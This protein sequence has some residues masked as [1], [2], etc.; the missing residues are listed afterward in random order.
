MDL[1]LHLLQLLCMLHLH[2][3]DDLLEADEPLE[4]LLVPLREHR[5]LPILK[6]F[7]LSHIVH[8]SFVCKLFL[9]LQDLSFALFQV[10]L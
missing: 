2:I 4:R 8:L 7:K 9:E 5:L 6:H 1:L 10:P 3:L